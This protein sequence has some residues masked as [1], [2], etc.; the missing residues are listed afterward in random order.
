MGHPILGDLTLD[1][2]DANGKP[3]DTILIAGENGCGKSTV[4][5]FLYSIVSG[6]LNT[7]AIVEIEK[8][9]EEIQL[10]FYH[11]GSPGGSLWVKDSKE[12]DASYAS[13][14]YRNQYQMAGIF[15]DVEI[16]FTSNNPN[17]VTS[18]VLDSENN[19]KKSN[20]NMPQLIKQL[21]IDI[22]ASDDSDISRAIR[23]NPDST[24]KSLDIQERIPRFT[25]A[26]NRMFESLTYSRIE[27]KNNTKVIVFEKNG[28]SIPIDN[29]SSGEKQ[30]VYRGC[31]LLKDVNALNGAFVFI[32]EP[33]ISLHPTW[34]QKIMDYYKGIFTDNDGNQT[35]QI[36]AVTHSPF[37][38]HNEN[39]KDDKIIVL[40]R[41]KD[42]KIVVN[43]KPEYYKCTSIEAVSDAFSISNF[44]SDKPTVYVE[45]RTDE[46]Y[47]KRTI[48][49]FNMTVPFQFKWI[50]YLDENGQEVNTGKDSLNKAI[51]FLTM[52]NLPIVNICLFDC[53]ANK[54]TE[55][56]ENVIIT[57]LPHYENDRSIKA[58]IEN[59]LVFGKINI[60]PYRHYNSK[61]DDYGMEKRIP[62][63]EKMS[64]CEYICSLGDD[65]LKAVFVNLKQMIDL[66]I[67]L[68]N[69]K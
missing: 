24:Y 23:D 54:S 55:K 16:N 28:A 14:Q 42:G 22:Q 26:F 53:D 32:D 13:S 35:S 3:V 41:N 67:Q 48:E 61:T 64:C 40:S 15:S 34:Q 17:S 7:D 45:G 44:S 62:V 57:G 50:G 49:V 37:I 63:F 60:E 21:L 66:L 46:K 68:Y 8:D 56:K 1:F 59:A 10:T 51:H 30:I 52:Q 36:F 20:S 33:E 9:D 5:E 58:G 47:F 43:D 27:N 25:K 11:R 29:L 65:I 6:N 18:M 69:G 39:R 38:I 12:M 31:F 4:L 19:S 2:C